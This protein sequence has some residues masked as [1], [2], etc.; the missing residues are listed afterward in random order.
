MNKN[1]SPKSSRRRI[2]QAGV[3]IVAAGA[4]VRPAAAADEPPK[5]EK[6]LVGYQDKPN[7]DGQKCINCQVFLPPNA[8]VTVAGTISP[9]G[10]CG[11][12]TP[13]T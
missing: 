1:E 11:V 12:Y 7:Q 4:A 9:N 6:T 3:A 13:K 10:W 2:L 5:V 8:C